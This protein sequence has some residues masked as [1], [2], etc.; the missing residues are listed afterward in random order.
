MITTRKS[1]DR[2]HFDFGWL[3]THHTF[4]FG[5]YHDRNHMNFRT[6]RVINDDV[7]APG[8]GFGM[9]PH[10]DMEIITY[11]LSGALAHKDSMG[12]GEALRPGEVQRMSAGSGILHSEFNA[13]K[14][15]P[16]H[17]LQIWIMPEKR[18]IEPSYEQ[19]PF[20]QA[21][22]HNKLRVV[23]SPDARDGSLKIHQDA[24]IHA[25]MLDA[26]KSVMY[27][28]KPGRHAWLQIAR[29]ELDLNG[30]KLAAGDGAAVSDEKSLTIRA[31]ENSEFLL[32]DL[33]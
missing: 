27:E 12:N 3:N 17:L 9:H 18:G 21:E 6:L 33:A 19:K 28:L 29:G 22:R 14:T 23:V 1:N 24:S 2:G 4:S 11:V 30:T 31:V 25:S 5:D 20:A 13:S 10:K 16:V 7:V 32:F 15:D 26:G 8:A